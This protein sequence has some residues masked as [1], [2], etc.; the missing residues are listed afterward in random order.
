MEHY[1]TLFD[2]GFAPQGLAL[3][4]SLQ[5]HAGEHTLWV[6]CM[7]D[8]V[9]H[10]LKTLAIP[11]VRTVRLSE[12]ETDPLLEVKPGRNRA[13]YCWTLTPFTHD[14]VFERDQSAQRVTYIDADVWL[15]ADPTPVFDA[16]EASGAAVQITEHAYAPEH[17][18]TATSGRYCVQFL[19]MD[20]NRS[21]PVRRWWQDRC[22]EWCFA[23]SEDG[24]FGDQKY[25]DDWL[26]R[27]GELIYVADPKSWFQGPWNATRFPYSEAM[28]YHFH[29]LRLVCPRSVFPVNREYRIPKPH[30]RCL[31]EPYLEDVADAVAQIARTT[32][33]G[34]TRQA[35]KDK[36]LKRCNAEPFL[37]RVVRRVLGGL[38]ARNADTG[39]VPL[40]SRPEKLV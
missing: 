27:F 28:M 6:L 33:T 31:Y 8:E 9:A 17:D 23:R 1:I 25:L 37:L 20:R 18:Q 39:T 24:K 32:D 11:D 26:Q 36:T 3:H 10:L 40:P 16:F 5:R 4:R 34:P 14:I 38:L 12:I 30:W 22:I 29:G 35:R 2:V 13:E 7:D 15:A 21:L 19:T